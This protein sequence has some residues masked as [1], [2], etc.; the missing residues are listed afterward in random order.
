MASIRITR[1]AGLMPELQAKQLQKEQAQVA[2]NTLLWDGTLRAMP[3]WT[4][5]STYVQAPLSLIPNSSVPNGF[6]VDY[7]LSKAMA[8]TRPMSTGVVGLSASNY[9]QD[10]I[11]FRSL[12]GGYLNLN[13]GV[14]IGIPRPPFGSVS[15]NIDT[16]GQTSDHRPIAYAVALVAVR[17]DGARSA[18]SVLGIA[19]VPAI[20][21]TLLYP[22]SSVTFSFTV[23]AGYTTAYAITRF[24]VYV[25][26]VPVDMAQKPLNTDDVEWQL[27]DTLIC[28]AALAP[29]TQTTVT[30]GSGSSRFTMLSEE[31]FPPHVP[32]DVMGFGQ[33]EGGRAF[34]ASRGPV[35]ADSYV[36]VSEKF[37][38]HGWPIRNVYRI[39]ERLAGAVAHYDTI[40]VPTRGAPYR[41][42]LR[43]GDKGAQADAVPYP[44]PLPFVGGLCRTS[45]G[46]AYVSSEG[47]VGLAGEDAKILTTSVL[48]AGDKLYG[49]F[50]LAD[51]QVAEWYSGQYYGFGASTVG[52]IVDIPDAMHG[53]HPLAELV[54][55]DV[56][57][58]PA[59]TIV[60][61]IGVVIA[62]GNSSYVQPLPGTPSYATAQLATY[63]WRSKVFVSPGLVTMSAAK[64]VG[65]G[66]VLPVIFRL[67]ADGVLIHTRTVINSEPFRLPSQHKALEWEIELE[68]KR[69]VHE[70][71]VATSMRELTEQES[72]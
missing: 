66:N 20:S 10:S 21:G 50:G 36:S 3:A 51:V 18:P 47:L 15:R 39:Q 25:T 48:N 28:G 12:V 61:D 71:H 41:V 5:L 30:W 1:F 49:N 62:V 35:S 23:T 67:Y 17:A 11:R 65:V 29:P 34:V 32:G 59:A 53:Q 14:P 63:K 54:T 52:V 33:T 68:G 46:A 19:G 56:P 58:R 40:Y 37:L 70:V 24:E 22:N 16:A 26:Q 55:F 31:M 4:V 43:E 8:T 9:N 60:T 57:G 72:A 7:Y 45:F 44:S 2:H 6:V 27:F 64:V 38:W 42:A 69:T 13:S